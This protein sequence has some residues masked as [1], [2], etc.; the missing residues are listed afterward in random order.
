MFTAW[1]EKKYLATKELFS[2][3]QKLNDED[4]NDDA[5]DDDDDANTIFAKLID[6]KN[7]IFVA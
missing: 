3:S 2:L 7:L 5:D 4:D 1:S 6:A